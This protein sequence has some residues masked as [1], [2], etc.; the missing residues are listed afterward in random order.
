MPLD[1]EQVLAALRTVLDPEIH[2]DIVTLNM[3]K[4]VRIDG[5]QVHVTVELTTPACP[6]KEAIR[7]DVEAAL[8]KAGAQSVQ[9][10]MI[11]ALGAKEADLGRMQKPLETLRGR[12]IAEDRVI[13]A[14]PQSEA[15]RRVIGAPTP[16]Q[17]RY[18]LNL[19][20][21][22]RLFANR[23]ANDRVVFVPQVLNQRRKGFGF[24][25]RGGGRGSLFG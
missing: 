11:A 18:V 23:R 5:S 15:S 7:R 25:D 9:V 21:H 17:I 2:K 20:E 14:F 8:S 3:V 22:D 4:D 24:E 1:R 13:A 12:G 19:V 16:R 10:E 6:L